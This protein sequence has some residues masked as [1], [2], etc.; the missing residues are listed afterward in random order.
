MWQFFGIFLMIMCVICLGIESSN[1]VEDE[2]V[3]VDP[4]EENGLSKVM[5]CF[6]AIVLVLFCAILLSSKSLLIRTYN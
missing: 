6:L 3:S 1:K 2:V 5:N 4:E